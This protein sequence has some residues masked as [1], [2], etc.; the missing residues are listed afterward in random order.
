MLDRILVCNAD[1]YLFPEAQLVARHFPV[2]NRAEASPET[3][4]RA[5]EKQDLVWC[6]RQ[7]LQR[8][9]QSQDILVLED[10]AVIK[11]DF[12]SRLYSVL[13][14]R[15]RHYSKEAWLDLKLYSQPRLQAPHF[16]SLLQI[17]FL[18][19][20]VWY[21]LFSPFQKLRA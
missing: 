9:P 1:R 15:A 8:R 21:V 14:L 20:T 2:I 17:D 18:K 19:S 16:T 4:I 10:D 12:F 3:N 11:D 5:K 13:N 6:L 7:V